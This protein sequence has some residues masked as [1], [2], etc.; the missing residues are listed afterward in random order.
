MA[1]IWPTRCWGLGRSTPVN[2]NFTDPYSK[3]SY[4]AAQVLTDLPP[5]GT[6]ISQI[7][8]LRPHIW[9][10][11]SWHIFHPHQTL[12][13]QIPTLRVHI[14]RVSSW[15]I[16]SNP[17]LISQIPTLRAHI[18]ET[19]SQEIYSLKWQCHRFLI[20]GLIFGGSG[21]DI[22]TPFPQWYQRFLLW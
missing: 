2:S 17:P 1:H 3:S 22:S 15:H 14:W 13:S 18:W 16:Y 11:R 10:T 12:I 8:T 5:S 21:L 9:Q 20:W 6:G 4:L 19:R 7:P